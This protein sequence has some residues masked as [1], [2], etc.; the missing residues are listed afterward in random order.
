MVLLIVA[1]IGIVRSCIHMFAPDGGA[2]SIAGIDVNV[3]GGDAIIFT[4]ALWGSEQ[5]LMGIVEIV[6]CIRFRNLVPFM[7]II[8]TGEYLLRILVGHIKPIVFAWTP[9]GAWA[10]YIVLPVAVVMFVLSMI[11]LPPKKM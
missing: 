5:L 4:F 1:I 2:W 9:P 7:Y 6:V 3:A 8:I 11:R 10:D